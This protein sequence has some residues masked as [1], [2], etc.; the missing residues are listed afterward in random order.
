[1]IGRNW[2]TRITLMLTKPLYTHRRITKRF[3]FTAE[4]FHTIT[5]ANLTQI[6]NWY[7]LVLFKDV[8]PTAEAVKIVLSMLCNVRWKTIISQH[9]IVA[10]FVEL[11]NYLATET[12]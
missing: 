6:I 2:A 3:T 8:V 4:I 7:I 5:V 11:S 9:A 12:E 10:C 1:M